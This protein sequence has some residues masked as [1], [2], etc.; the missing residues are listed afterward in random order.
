MGWRLRPSR[1]IPCLRARQTGPIGNVPSG[2]P[3]FCL[4]NEKSKFLS[5][6]YAFEK[7]YFD[8]TFKGR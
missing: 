6:T 7:N 8:L 1:G 5:I 2:G 3:G 4:S